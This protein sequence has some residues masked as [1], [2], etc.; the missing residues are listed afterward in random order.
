MNLLIYPFLNVIRVVIV[1]EF[2]EYW[3]ANLL[4]G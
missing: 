3:V 2:R 1:L 4:R